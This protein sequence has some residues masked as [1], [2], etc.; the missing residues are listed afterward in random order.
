LAYQEKTNV[1]AQDQELRS[2]A[3]ETLSL[4]FSDMPTAR[5]GASGVTS[6]WATIRPES[7]RILAVIEST[8]LTA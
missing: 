4:L 2:F 8:G 7:L 6:E 1:E 5:T 3:I